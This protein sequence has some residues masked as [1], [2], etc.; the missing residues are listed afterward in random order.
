MFFSVISEKYG[1]SLIDTFNTEILLHSIFSHV[2]D[3]KDK[4]RTQWS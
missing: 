4:G 2:Y 3:L 1:N